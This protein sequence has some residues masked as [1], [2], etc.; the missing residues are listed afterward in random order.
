MVNIWNENTRKQLETK[1]RDAVLKVFLTT[2]T[3]LEAFLFMAI[4][5]R[6]LNKPQQYQNDI[7]KLCSYHAV[8]V[9]WLT[10][11]L[12]RFEFQGMSFLGMHS[13]IEY[14]QKADL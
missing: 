3:A 14:M 8:G 6:C 11:Q 9:E 13:L 5:G 4:E 2:Y 1:G 7:I 12:P 10:P